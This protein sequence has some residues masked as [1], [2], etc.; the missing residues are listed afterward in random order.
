LE[1]GKEFKE[2]LRAGFVGRMGFEEVGIS[3][4]GGMVVDGLD[5]TV[6]GML[7]ELFVVGSEVMVDVVAERGG[8]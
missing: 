7:E 8:G 5:L 3:R 2:G 1:N 6:E 4:A